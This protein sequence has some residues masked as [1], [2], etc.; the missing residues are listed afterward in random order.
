LPSVIV[1]A[2]AGA[3]A[4]HIASGVT[5]YAMPSYFWAMITPLVSLVNCGMIAG[6]LPT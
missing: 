1:A 5:L 2:G 3:V 6:R 4:G